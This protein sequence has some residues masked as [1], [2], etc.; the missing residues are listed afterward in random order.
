M[1]EQI[2]VEVAIEILSICLAIAVSNKD[3]ETIKKILK[4]QEKVYLG[5]EKAIEEAI[6]KYGENVKKILEDI[7]E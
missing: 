7:N 3:E 5:N 6:T 1:R 4:L 2:R